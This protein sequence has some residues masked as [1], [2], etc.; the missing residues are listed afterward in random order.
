M[1][2]P[3]CPLSVLSARAVN[4]YRNGNEADTA[5]I[6]KQGRGYQA[7]DGECEVLDMVSG[8]DIPAQK[9]MKYDACRLP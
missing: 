8:Y 4:W 1:F 9:V 2:Y 7:Q 3:A 5:Q 6:S